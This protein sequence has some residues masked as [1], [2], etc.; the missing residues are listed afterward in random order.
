LVCAFV[1][2]A[3]VIPLTENR[4]SKFLPEIMDRIFVVDP[5]KRISIPEIKEHPWFKQ[6]EPSQLLLLFANLLK[7]G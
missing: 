3:S 4:Y 6:Y 5:K 1:R 7:N 2:L